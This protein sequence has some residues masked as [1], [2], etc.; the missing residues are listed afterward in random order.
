MGVESGSLTAADCEAESERRMEYCADLR[1]VPTQT[2]MSNL[3]GESSLTQLMKSTSPIPGQI[4]AA[5]ELLRDAGGA[6][7][8]RNRISDA[9]RVE[10][11]RR[12]G[13]VQQYNG[14]TGVYASR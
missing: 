5:R 9:P 3:M 6:G 12:L 7:K 10:H 13:E 1:A 14:W 2:A 8:P 4:S 11:E